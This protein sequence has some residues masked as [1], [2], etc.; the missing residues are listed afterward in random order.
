MC[1][2]RASPASALT[3]SSYVFTYAVEE[4]VKGDLGNQVEVTSTLGGGMCGLDGTVGRRVAFLLTRRQ[5]A[6]EP[7]G[8]EEVDAETLHRGLL[9]LPER[10][11]LGRAVFLAGGHF[12]LARDLLLGSQ[13]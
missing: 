7:W 5:D 9:P 6:W 10:D 11:G 4:D 12:G 2:E 8:V 3:C 13:G 1:R